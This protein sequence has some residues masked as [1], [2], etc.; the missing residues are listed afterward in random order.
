MIINDRVIIKTSN[1]NIS[2]YKSIGYDVSS[3]DNIEISINDLPKT[4]KFK[5]DV[6]CD[7]CLSINNISYF[8]YLRNIKED[9]YFCKKCSNIRFKETSLKRYDVEHPMMLDEFKE[10]QK[11]SNIE[12]YGVEYSILNSDVKD[13]AKKT[14]LSN[15][16][17][18][19]FMKTDEFKMRSKETLLE[20]YGV[21]VPVHNN[22]IRNKIINTN[23]IRYGSEFPFGSNKI[24]DKISNIKLDKY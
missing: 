18:D 19:S 11:S 20:K 17:Y 6:K 4:S 3:G 1:K 13:K 5:I 16:G 10:K 22:D 9:K 24:R 23:L 8:S 12:K 2:Y 15:Y 14:L 7:N 21:E